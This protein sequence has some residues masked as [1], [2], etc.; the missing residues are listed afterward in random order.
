MEGGFEL[1]VRLRGGVDQ[2]PDPPGGVQE[3]AVQQAFLVPV[4]GILFRGAIGVVVG[5]ARGILG[6]LG[7]QDAAQAGLGT[8]EEMVPPSAL[9]SMRRSPGPRRRAE[10]GLATGV[11]APAERASAARR[12]RRTSRVFTLPVSAGRGAGIRVRVRKAV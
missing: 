2:G 8:D 12:V 1:R 3:F 7:E 11:W 6:G 10:P 4:Y 9:C 5:L